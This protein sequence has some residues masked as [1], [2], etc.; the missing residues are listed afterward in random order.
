MTS[1]TF[2]GLHGLQFLD[3][4][5]NN[6]SS[7]SSNSFKQSKDLII[8]HLHQNSISSVH[9]R[10][11]AG[12]VSLN[13]LTLHDNALS[14]IT[15]GTLDSLPSLSLLDISNN[16]WRCDCDITWIQ[17]WLQDQ[18]AQFQMD[19]LDD[20]VCSAPLNLNGV[21]LITFASN[22]YVPCLPPTTA[23]ESTST[24]EPDVSTASQPAAVTTKD[25]ILSTAVKT[26]I[27]VCCIVAALVILLLVGLILYCRHKR[28][29]FWAP[30]KAQKHDEQKQREAIKRDN[31]KFKARHQI[32]SFYQDP[33][34][35]DVSA[36]WENERR[37]NPDNPEKQNEQNTMKQNYVYENPALDVG[38][39]YDNSVVVVDNNGAT[40]QSMPY[41]AYSNGYTNDSK[42]KSGEDKSREYPPDHYQNVL[43]LSA[44]NLIKTGGVYPES[45]QVSGP[46]FQNSDT[47]AVNESYGDINNHIDS[48]DA[49]SI[50]NASDNDDKYSGIQPPYADNQER[51]TQS[52]NDIELNPI[53]NS[54]EIPNSLQ[55]NND[56]ELNYD[57]HIHNGQQPYQNDESQDTHGHLDKPVNQEPDS[58]PRA[59]DNDYLGPEE[60]AYQHLDKNDYSGTEE[61]AYQHLD[62]NDYSGPEEHA[63]QHLDKN[64][65]DK[66]NLTTS[67]DAHGGS[68]MYINAAY[69]DNEDLTEDHLPAHTNAHPTN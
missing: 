13:V 52:I 27:I 26:A 36:I 67:T 62:K 10:A 40:V 12:L 1:Q 65:G 34:S 49:H 48:T 58:S 30:A 18:S 54:Q 45:H 16:P 31:L 41:G 56:L 17:S 61:H 11:F 20:T 24:T 6:I 43:P 55:N 50:S 32:G 35:G 2:D 29:A 28:Y 8:L 23:A 14:S 68:G 39:T 15:Q 53:D 69:D 60:H 22:N 47:R 51:E 46:S 21:P 37:V 7:I 38:D 64:S 63:Y 25:P 33:E 19:H 59:Y 3:L 9:N 4:F 44:E 5:Q 66:M 57:D 42:A